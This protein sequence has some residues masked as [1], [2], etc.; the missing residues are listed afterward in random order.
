MWSLKF[1]VLNKD[2]IY[3]LLTAQYKVTDYLYPAD[4][5]KKGNKINIFCIHILEGEDAEIEKF[6]NSLKK[7][8]KVKEFE[9]NGKEVITLIAEEE[10]FYELLFAAEL[11]HPSPVVIKQGY[12]QWH[13]A[14]F[15]RNLL[16][17]IIKEIEKWKDKFPEFTLHSLAKTKMDEIYFPKIRPQLPEKQKQ[18]FQL[19]L[20]RGYYIWP[21]NVDLRDLA[22]EMGISISTFQEH[23]R[24]AEA[25]LMPLIAK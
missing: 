9:D 13:I 5:F 20:K 19:A 7:N 6:K 24:K 10:Y 1:T 11:Y 22:K 2:S 3:T 12:E 23:I 25:K 21:R 15:N 16:E 17:I 14:S 8:K 18:A 4:Y